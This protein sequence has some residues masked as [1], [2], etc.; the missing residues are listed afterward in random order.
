MFSQALSIQI[1]SGGQTGVDR[2]AL[3]QGLDSGFK[4]G[5]YCPKGRRAEDGPIDRKYPLIETT[6]G[7]VG[8]T[9]RNVL[10]S[11]ATIIIAKGSLEG[12]SALTQRFCQEA[13]KPHLVIDA[14]LLAPAEGAKLLLAFYLE[15]RVHAFNFAGP[16]ASGWPQGY[17]YT[18]QLIKHW[19]TLLEM[20]PS[21]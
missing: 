18:K 16:R 5:G 17:H 11:P 12:G 4:I 6:G 3:D 20:L 10:E 15:T 7:Y 21:P 14:N 1:L 13:N 8:R 9:Q 19:V 2:A